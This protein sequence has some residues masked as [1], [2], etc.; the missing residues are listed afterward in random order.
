MSFSGFLAAR[1]NAIYL[2]AKIHIYN[3][4]DSNITVAKRESNEMKMSY[5]SAHETRSEDKR[6]RSEIWKQKSVGVAYDTDSNLKSRVKLRLECDR[7]LMNFGRCRRNYSIDVRFLTSEA[8][9]RE[10]NEFVTSSR[11][12][13]SQY[14]S[15]L[16]ELIHAYISYHVLWK[17]SRARIYGRIIDNG[18]SV[19]QIHWL[20]SWDVKPVRLSN[21]CLVNNLV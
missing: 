10:G 1:E 16:L 12:W 7:L 21:R 18:T 4:L 2:S 17:L 13:L 5:G 6:K 15:H 8:G 9:G 14:V 20:Y 19:R 11:V 3:S